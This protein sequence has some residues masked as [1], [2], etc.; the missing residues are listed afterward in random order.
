[1]NG[2]PEHQRPKSDD[3]DFWDV[4]S[5]KSSREVQW[6]DISDDWQQV[7]KPASQP[8]PNESEGQENE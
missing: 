1:M 4:W 5:N 6:K 7:A 3:P 2:L 8:E